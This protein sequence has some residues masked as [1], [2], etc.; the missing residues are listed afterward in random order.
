MLI[1]M[2]KSKLHQIVVTEANL[3]YEGSITIDEDLL[4]MAELLP[5]EKV[6]IV[7]INNGERF[8]TYTI[9]GPRGSRICCLN[10]PAA[11]KVQVQDRVIVISYADMS[12]EE[13]KKHKPKV[14]VLNKHNEPIDVMNYSVYATE[15]IPD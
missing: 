5:Y 3:F 1:T 9:P 8:E 4:E 6:Q 13:A 10:G 15:I 11:R 2:F 14:V 7:N 12:L